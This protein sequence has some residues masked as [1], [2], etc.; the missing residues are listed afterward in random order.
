MTVHRVAVLALDGVTP[1]DLAIPAQVFSPR[2]ETP[3]ELV[4]R[5]LARQVATTSG[6]ALV[7]DGGLD[8]IRTWVSDLCHGICSQERQVV[9]IP[10]D[11]SG[12]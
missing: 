10:Q 1:L 8:E 12:A 11:M 4:M 7:V 5:G 2:P 9:A 3:Y 6:F